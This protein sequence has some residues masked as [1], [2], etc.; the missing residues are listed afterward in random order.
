MRVVLDGA[1]LERG[2]QVRGMD[3]TD[4]AAAAGLSSTTVAS[5]VS[6]KAV[7]MST[8]LAV[9]QA[10]KTRPIVEGLQEL[11]PGLGQGP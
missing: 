6:G 3:L 5:A 4:L 9:A 8:A 7:N 2:L 11:V 1:K 10:L